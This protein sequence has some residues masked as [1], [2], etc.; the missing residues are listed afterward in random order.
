MATGQL[1][2]ITI[3]LSEHTPHGKTCTGSVKVWVH[4]IHENSNFPF[5]LEPKV[6]ICTILECILYLRFYSF[7]ADILLL[8][9]GID[10]SHNTQKLTYRLTI[11]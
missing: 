8:L 10:M 2:H 11:T 7:S 6:S 3:F 5:K 1:P 4:I 9:S